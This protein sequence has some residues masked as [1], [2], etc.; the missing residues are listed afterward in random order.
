MENSLPIVGPKQESVA[1]LKT[2]V[3]RQGGET[4][5]GSLEHKRYFSFFFSFFLC[6]NRFNRYICDVFIKK[7]DILIKI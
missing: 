5:M 3:T 6:A 2:P 7:Q 1:S 4:G